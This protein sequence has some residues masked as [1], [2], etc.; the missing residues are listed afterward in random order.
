MSFWC[1]L[2][3]QPDAKS[4]AG[5]S[6]KSSNTAPISARPWKI[7]KSARRFRRG[8]EKFLNWLA[9]FGDAL[10]NSKIGP[11]ISARPRTDFLS[12]R[13][14]RRDLG[15]FP[16]RPADFGD[17]SDGFFIGS[18]ISAKV[19]RDFS[20]A[21]RNRRRVGGFFGGYAA[22]GDQ[23]RDPFGSLP[24][25]AA[26]PAPTCWLPRSRPALG[27]PSRRP[28]ARPGSCS[29]GAPRPAPSRSV[30]SFLRPWRWHTSAAPTGAAEAYGENAKSPAST[31]RFAAQLPLPPRGQPRLTV[32]MQSPRLPSP[33]LQRHHP[34]PRGDSRVSTPIKP[35]E[36]GE[37]HP[38]WSI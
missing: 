29:G 16:N 26:H 10:E 13:R 27:R 1:A 5:R 6:E 25:A 37:G 14:F 24:G 17:A 4:Y 15:K 7:P 11:P 12:A 2:A 20:R 18:P 21:R 28:A 38:S 32:K 3:G 33:T 22:G 30:P 9:D 35:L 36:A 31:A 34:C 19:P 8:F 23:P